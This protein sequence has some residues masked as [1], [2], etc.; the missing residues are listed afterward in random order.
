MTN[1]IDKSVSQ[2]VTFAE[3]VESPSEVTY[4]LERLERELAFG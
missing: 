3:R 1:N 2:D 4:A